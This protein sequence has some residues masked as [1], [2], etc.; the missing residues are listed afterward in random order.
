MI[1]DLI[2]FPNF[3][4]LQVSS[5]APF[6][7]INFSSFLRRPL[8]LNRLRTFMLSHLFMKISLLRRLPLLLQWALS[9][10]RALES[11]KSSGVDVADMSNYRPT[12]AYKYSMLFFSPILFGADG[13]THVKIVNNSFRLGLFWLDWIIIGQPDTLCQ[14]PI[15]RPSLP[16]PKLV[17]C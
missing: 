6:I 15:K 8:H 12:I 11:W 2:S 3:F 1:T 4:F 17:V 14:R 16:V 7:K 5:S 9:Q 10:R 13:K